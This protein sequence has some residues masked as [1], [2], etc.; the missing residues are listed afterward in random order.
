M[1]LF[2]WIST[3]VV[4][5]FIIHNH[6]DLLVLKLLHTCIYIHLYK[7]NCIICITNRKVL[8]NMTYMKF[9]EKWQFRANLGNCPQ[10][11]ISLSPFFVHR[12]KPTADYASFLTPRACIDMRIPNKS[13]ERNRITQSPV[14]DGVRNEAYPVVGFRRCVLFYLVNVEHHYH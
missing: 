13:M 4:D 1:E 12:R 8:F 5:A 10:L 6:P 3:L 11:K 2:K 9:T 7:F 14:V